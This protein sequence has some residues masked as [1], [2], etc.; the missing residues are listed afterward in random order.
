MSR[1][2]VAGL[3]L[4]TLAPLLVVLAPASADQAPCDAPAAGDEWPTFGRDLANTRTQQHAGDISPAT[5]PTL[6]P[7]WS[8]STGASGNVFSDLNG[9]PI[10]SGGCVYLNTAGGDVIALEA[11]SGAELWRHHVT[12]DPGT[13]AGLGGTFVSSPAVTDEAVL[14]LVNQTGAPYVLALSKRA[15]ADGAQ[16][17]LWRSKPIVAGAGYYTNATPVVSGGLLLAG[18]SPAE[19][20][21]DERG[22]ITIFDARTGRLLKRVY[23][24]PEDAFA[25]GYAGGGIWTAPAVDTESGYAYA[26]TSNPYSK[27][28]EHENTNAVIKIDIDPTRRTFGEV[29]GSYKGLI[30]QYDPALREAVDPLCEAAGEDPNLQLVVGD[31]APC[32]QLDLDFG[33]PPNLFRDSTGRLVVGDLQKAGVYHAVDAG[34]MQSL[35]KATVGGSCPA[36]NAAAW[37][38]D[39]G[40]V[41]GATA[42]GGAMVSLGQ[43]DGAVRWASPIADGTHYESTSSAGG[44]VFTVDN[45]GTLLAWEEATGLPLLKRPVQADTDAT[46]VGVSSSG[47]AIASGMVVVASGSAVVAYAPAA[48]G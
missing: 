46:T 23:T 9:T 35:W 11:G 18:F 20:D 40:S 8:F 34:S 29:V 14:T 6:Q 4:A 38:S 7:V 44:V 15:G 43:D 37:A 47:I 22:G 12:L 41:V 1:L 32:L 5:T 24:I 31:S 26:G 21:A 33:A 17:V 25:E 28:I 30:D 16:R 2:R 39:A 42:P 48:L 27:K 10:V 13:V 3:V 36:C 19:G 45:L